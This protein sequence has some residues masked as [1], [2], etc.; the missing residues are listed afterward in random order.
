MTAEP[1]GTWAKDYLLRHPSRPCDRCDGRGVVWAEDA[2]SCSMCR[3]LGQIPMTVDQIREAYRA[4]REQVCEGGRISREEF[5]RRC[6][7]MATERHPV[8][9]AAGMWLWAAREISSRIDA[10]RRRARGRW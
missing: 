2:G 4:I 8:N 5:D 7:M 9:T 6:T 1:A 3:G 10:D